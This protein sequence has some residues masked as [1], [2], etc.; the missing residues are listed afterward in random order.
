[1]ILVIILLYLV[2][3]AQNIH[4][5]MITVNE[6]GRSSPLCCMYGGC[7]CSSLHSALSSIYQSNTVIN[8]TSPAISLHTNISIGSGNLKY[9]ITITSKDGTVVM[10]NNTGTLSC[11]MCS[12]VV[13]EAITW[14]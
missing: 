14:D 2:T 3:A 1:M 12:E 9:N 11:D 8:I 4:C 13:I 6:N 7:V 10:C 5:R